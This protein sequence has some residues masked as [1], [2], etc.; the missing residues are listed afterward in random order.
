MHRLRAR[1]A[2][3]ATE[4]EL[5]AEG[6]KSPGVLLSVQGYIAG[7]AIAGIIIAFVAGALGGDPSAYRSVGDGP[8]PLVCR[9][10]CRPALA[11]AVRGHHRRPLSPGTSDR[12]REHSP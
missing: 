4:E 11:L 5:V 10:L 9:G 7:G 1:H 2:A 8:Q 6:D 12:L 3:D